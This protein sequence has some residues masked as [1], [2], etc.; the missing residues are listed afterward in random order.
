VN[1]T[2][3][4]WLYHSVLNTNCSDYSQTECSISNYYY[5]ASELS[6]ATTGYYQLSSNGSIGLNGY[7]YEEMFSPSVPSRNL[8]AEKHGELDFR[9]NVYFQ[10]G[11]TYV[12]VVTS[13][14]PN[15]TGSFWIL[16]A[17]PNYIS[18]QHI[19][20]FICSLHFDDFNQL[21]YQ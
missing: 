7:I 18:V 10:T 17:G 14:I 15:E 21:M 2:I 1:T 9:M 8:I 13:S 5:K 6:V 16:A 11:M 12:L 20:K 4:Q 3:I 19:G